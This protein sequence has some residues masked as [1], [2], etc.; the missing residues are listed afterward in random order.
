MFVHIEGQ[1]SINMSHICNVSLDEKKVVFI[2]DTLTAR[3][4]WNFESTEE[5]KKVYT[6]LLEK[7]QSIKIS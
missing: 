2:A 3:E 6:A 7:I 1:S 5:A 4:N